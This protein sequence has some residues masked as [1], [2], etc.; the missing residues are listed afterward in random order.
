MKNKIFIFIFLIFIT[1]LFGIQNL[2]VY[3]VFDKQSYRMDEPI[4]VKFVVENNGTEPFSFFISDIKPYTFFFRVRTEKN[5]EVEKTEFLINEIQKEIDR[6]TVRKVILNPGE[7]FVVVIDLAEWFNFSQEGFY[8]VEGIFSPSLLAHIYTGFSTGIFKLRIRPPLP[9]EKAIAQITEEKKEFVNITGLTPYEVVR[10]MLESRKMRDW[11]SFFQFFDLEELLKAFPKFYEAY[12]KA[13]TTE[14]REEV[15]NNFKNYLKTYW[16]DPI[17]S[18]DIFRTLIERD[19]A[20]VTCD[21]EYAHEKFTYKIQYTYYL[22]LNYQN[23][24]LIYNYT[25]TRLKY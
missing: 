19:K 5:E 13:G 14:R 18:Y 21:V 20:E 7:S 11:D 16:E 25:A 10:R 15:I 4:P 9:I 8:Y 2:R 12:E 23:K 1:P 3:L 17:V 6:N 24:W 22:Y